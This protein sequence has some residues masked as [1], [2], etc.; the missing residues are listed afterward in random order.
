MRTSHRVVAFVIGVALLL[1]P[2]IARADIYFSNYGTNS[3]GRANPDGTGINLSLITGA[4]T[5]FGLA[6]DGSHV[7]WANAGSGTIG[8]ANLDGTA[9]NQSFITGASGP[10]GLAVNGSHIFWTNS[11]TNKIGR[12][13]ID[14]TAVDQAFVTG[15][16]SPQGMALSGSRIY[17][18]NYDTNSIGRANI[19]GTGVDPTFISGATAPQGVAVSDSHVYWTNYG[20]AGR[21]GRANLDG[22]GVDQSF[23]TGATYPVSV[24]VDNTFVY[25]G[26]V[27]MNTVGRANLDG[28]GVSQ[29]FMI[30][31]NNLRGLVAITAQTIT[32]P[33]PATTAVNAGPVTLAATA[34]S[35]LPVSYTSMTPTVCAVA[36]RQV[37]LGAAGRC[38]ITATQ[39]G[40]SRYVAAAPVRASFAVTATP[41]PRATA[42]V[43][44]KAKARK[45]KLFVAVTPKLTKA[46]HWQF[47]VQSKKRSGR[48][49]TLA[50]R[51]QTKG[52]NQ[53]LTV[54]LK[55]GTYRAVIKPGFGYT[56]VT[57]R[58]VKLKR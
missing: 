3:L 22:T 41:R 18:V 48:W 45:S 40:N 33:V 27:T 37:T 25:W 30:G 38:T 14:G 28:T 9:V 42:S 50:T 21:I 17:W 56:G 8:R 51:Y 43:T 32:F 5:P 54:N 20:I 19:D 10:V 34:S 6:V 15:A 29:S 39:P 2:G 11:F 13:N 52:A 44:V 23:I 24:A 16:G 31:L 36:G 47:R 46:T 26:N 53:T 58:A 4:S 49:R 12:A 1:L 57:S 7:Y 55:K 35:G